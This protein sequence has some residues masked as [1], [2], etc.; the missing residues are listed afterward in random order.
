MQILAQPLTAV[1]RQRACCIAIHMATKQFRVF[2]G[3]GFVV[4]LLSSELGLLDDNHE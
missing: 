1:W 2:F 4:V 3:I